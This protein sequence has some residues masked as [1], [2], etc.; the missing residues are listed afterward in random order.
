[1]VYYQMQAHNA[2]H[3]TNTEIGVMNNFERA[4]NVNT[5]DNQGRLIQTIS[6]LKLSPAFK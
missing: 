2:D 3:S 5:G 6:G 4:Q 1:M